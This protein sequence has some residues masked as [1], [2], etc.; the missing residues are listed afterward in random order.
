[1][2]GPHTRGVWG[3]HLKDYYRNNYIYVYYTA[4]NGNR[5]SRFIF[6]DGRLQDEK[7]L[8]DNIPN[9]M[10]HDGGRIKFG[11]DGKLYVTT[12]DATK[13]SSAQDINSW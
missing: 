6:N 3:P 10:F 11:P 12:G 1:M 7:F 8:L 13:P 4:E 5:V 9:A 2:K